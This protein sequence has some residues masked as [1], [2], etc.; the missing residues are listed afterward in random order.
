MEGYCLQIHELPVD[1]LE[2]MIIVGKYSPP[3]YDSRRQNDKTTDL[4]FSVK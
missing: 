3:Y 2:L 1:E 4:E